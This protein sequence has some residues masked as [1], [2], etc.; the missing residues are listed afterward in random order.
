M[1]FEKN[2]ITI[3][4]ISLYASL[5]APLV[6]YSGFIFPFITGHYYYFLTCLFIACIF[7]L[8][9]WLK[10]ANLDF[11]FRGL[12][13]HILHPSIGQGLFIFILALIF[14]SFTGYDIWR[15]FF[16][17]E[18]RLIGVFS[19]IFLGLYFLILRRTFISK[20]IKAENFL[21]TSIA[22][23]F[24]VALIGFIQFFSP[25]FVLNVETLERVGGLFGNPT[26][27]AGYLLFHVFWGFYFLHENFGDIRSKSSLGSWTILALPYLI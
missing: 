12:K 9:V 26:F 21:K 6:V 25:S 20:D 22:I 19:Y 2:L 11:S 16:S 23:S 5:F 3:S 8:P 1:N 7:Y 27:L 17:T 18:E 10:G 24:I 15:S 14:T 4:K 13:S